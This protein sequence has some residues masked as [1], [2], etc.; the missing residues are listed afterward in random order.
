MHTHINYIYKQIHIEKIFPKIFYSFM[1]RI[2]LLMKTP[3]EGS[4]RHAGIRIDHMATPL[5]LASFG[6][7]TTGPQPCQ[8][9]HYC[10]EQSTTSLP[11]PSGSFTASS[12]LYEAAQCTA[13]TAGYYCLGKVIYL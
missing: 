6:N 4:F 2:T 7:L 5:S 12:I 8:Q 9:G 10:P 3:T 13:C 11:C 1:K